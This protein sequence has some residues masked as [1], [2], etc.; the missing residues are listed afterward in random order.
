M[1]SFTS[2]NKT[3]IHKQFDETIWEA[4]CNVCGKSISGTLKNIYIVLAKEKW[5]II[6]NGDFASTILICPK[7][8]S[9]DPIGKSTKLEGLK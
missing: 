8:M 4:G 5:N 1:G 7:C 9:G 3:I 2:T 6:G